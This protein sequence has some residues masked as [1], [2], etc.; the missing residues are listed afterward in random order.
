MND[1]MGRPFDGLRDLRGILRGLHRILW[2]I[3]RYGLDVRVFGVPV[4]KIT[5]PAYDREY[6]DRFPPEPYPGQGNPQGS[7]G[8]G[9]A[10]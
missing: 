3:D 1:Q 5:V 4:F 2:K 6:D 7:A 10:T 8:P 9:G